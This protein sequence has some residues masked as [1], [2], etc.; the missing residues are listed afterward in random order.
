M[1]FQRPILSLTGKRVEVIVRD[2]NDAIR[3]ATEHQPSIVLLEN[4]DSIASLP[5]AD[6]VGTEA[7]LHVNKYVN[8]VS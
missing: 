6:H 2:L 8:L 7:T 5:N 3:E 1:Y 4:I